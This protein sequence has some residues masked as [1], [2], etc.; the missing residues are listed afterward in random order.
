M[1]ENR[2][3]TG[4]APKV[5]LRDARHGQWLKFI[6]PQRTLVATT[7]QE[8]L[9]VLE[10]IDRAAAEDA[11]YC[12]GFVSYEA[13]PAFDA[14]LAAHTPGRFPLAWFCLFRNVEP[15]D[16]P[17]P[18]ANALSR[19]FRWRPSVSRTEYYEA[20]HRVHAF[21]ESGDTYQVNYT[22]RLVSEFTSD[23]WEFF[24]RLVVAQNPPYGGYIDAGEWAICSASPELFFTRHGD[25]LES[26]PMKGTAA[27]G[28]T[29][30]ED[31]LMSE[32]LQASLKERAENVMIVDMVRNDFGRVARTGSVAAKRL[33][34]IERYPTIWQMTS[35]VTARTEQRLQNVFRATFPPASIT[36]APKIRTTQIIADLETT[37]RNIYTGTIGFVT[38]GGDAQ[39]NVA[40][41]T[42]LIDRTTGKAEYGAGSGIVWDSDAESEWE[43]CETKAKVLSAETPEFQLLETMRWQ[44]RSGYYL[45]TYHL[46]RLTESARYFGFRV[47][48]R[49]VRRELRSF[50]RTLPRK[51]QRIRLLVHKSGTISLEAFPLDRRIGNNLIVAVARKPVPTSDVFVYHKTTNRRVYESAMKEN[52]R[53]RDVILWNEKG[54]VTESTVANVFVDIGGRLFTPPVACGLLG[55]TMR[56]H[57]ISTGRVTERVISISELLRSPVVYLG[58]SVRGMYRVRVMR[59]TVHD[60]ETPDAEARRHA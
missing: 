39:F 55:G 60:L 32:Q 21:I 46:R 38:P 4:H 14:A 16:I 9:R 13:T 15:V 25:E 49:E 10:T 53:C 23:P 43:E 17:A 58:N 8:V 31:L 19:A 12:A 3:G 28:R 6:D 18:P 59:P 1:T 52:P 47:D 40:I 51:A 7:L 20:I 27:R 48:M 22:Y 34:E 35:T 57:L 2:A 37:R 33:F 42:A 26:R 54:E 50:A 44:P 56:A 41:R 36:G 11:L 5:I 24:L 45:K 29:L 30:E